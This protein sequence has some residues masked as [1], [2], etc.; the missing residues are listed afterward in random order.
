[1]GGKNGL[2]TSY[3]SLQREPVFSLIRRNLKETM[4]NLSQK[5]YLGCRLS[6]RVSMS[7]QPTAKWSRLGKFKVYLL[8][9]T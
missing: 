3:S 1:M 6:D 8:F 7:S 9:I 5:E 2:R 4:L